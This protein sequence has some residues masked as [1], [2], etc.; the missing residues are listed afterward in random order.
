MQR[1]WHYT[2]VNSVPKEN[3]TTE[4]SQIS[5]KCFKESSNSSNKKVPSVPKGEI[6]IIPYKITFIPKPR[7][8]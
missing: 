8:I 7:K 4:S 6:I 5:N 1:G 2:F 3:S